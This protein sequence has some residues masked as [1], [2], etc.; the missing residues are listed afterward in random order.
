[1]PTQYDQE[2]IEL[3]RSLYLKYGGKN[4]DAIEREMQKEFPGW[5]KQNLVDRGKGK[6][7][8]LGWIN[9]YGFD[10]S[11]KIHTEKL[12]TAV[13]DDTQDLYIGIRDVRKS[14]QTEVASSR[15]DRDKVYQYRDFCKLEIE[16]RKALDLS[17]DNLETFVSGY[18]KLIN[19][20]SEIDKPAAKLLVQHGETLIERAKAHYG[21]TEKID[22]RASSGA[23]EIG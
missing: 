13:N 16:A 19:W 20:L 12:T 3:C 4:H 10:N 1:M 7:E 11:L 14:L 15:A 9:R 21:D 6:D 8:R 5:R 23:N 17:R 2:T 18:E 22:N